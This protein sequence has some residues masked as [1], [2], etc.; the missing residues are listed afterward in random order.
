MNSDVAHATEYYGQKLLHSGILLH[1]VKFYNACKIY[2]ASYSSLI[3][4]T[5]EYIDSNTSHKIF[6]LLKLA[7]SSHKTYRFTEDVVVYNIYI[8]YLEHTTF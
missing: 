5:T 1:A 8:G 6:C 3:N 7:V 4:Y 2:K